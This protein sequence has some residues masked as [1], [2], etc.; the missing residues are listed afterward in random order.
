MYE[1]DS[2]PNFIHGWIFTARAEG[3]KRKHSNSWSFGENFRSSIVGEHDNIG[4][5]FDGRIL[6]SRAIRNNITTAVFEV[7]DEKTTESFSTFWHANMVAT[8]E[9]NITRRIIYARYHSVVFA[10]FY[11]FGS[12]LDWH[13]FSDSFANI[14]GVKIFDNFLNVFI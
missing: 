7:A 6:A 3:R 1:L 13:L 2:F 9:N 12:L 4:K 5:L 8:S 10:S 11:F 14:F